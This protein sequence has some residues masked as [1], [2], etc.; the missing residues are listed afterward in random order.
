MRGGQ[1]Y[2]KYNLYK[3]FDSVVV[4][5]RAL[6]DCAGADGLNRSIRFFNCWYWELLVVCAAIWT[7]GAD[8]LNAL[9]RMRLIIWSIRRWR[10]WRRW[11]RF[12]FLAL[13]I[14]CGL[15]IQYCIARWRHGGV[16]ISMGLSRRCHKLKV[17]KEGERRL[18]SWIESS[19]NV[20]YFFFLAQ[21]LTYTHTHTLYATFLEY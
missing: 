19:I 4:C 17:T 21:P 8:R 16:S 14:A 3:T 7:S 6:L 10:W 20:C 1:K 15:L 9:A 12:D 13:G 5:A 2:V 11:R 18:G